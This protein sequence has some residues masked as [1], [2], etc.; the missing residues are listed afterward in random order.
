[1]HTR[2]RARKHT[3]HRETVEFPEH[4]CDDLGNKS[5][6]LKS[7]KYSDH[8][9]SRCGKKREEEEKTHHKM[10][11]RTV[12][13]QAFVHGIDIERGQCKTRHCL[14]GETL[15]HHDFKVFFLSYCDTVL[16]VR[17]Y[18]PAAIHY[19]PE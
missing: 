5:R 19:C 9:R 18:S 6:T 3:V 1:M 10:M 12:T 13:V 11:S 4:Y 16:G 17:E 14:Q 7:H 15:L 8:W 2:A